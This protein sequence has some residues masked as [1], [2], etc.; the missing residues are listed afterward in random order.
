MFFLLFAAVGVNASGNIFYDNQ[1]L[2]IFVDFD[3]F[4]KS[5]IFFEN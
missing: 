5:C 3:Q 1:C 2:G 4:R